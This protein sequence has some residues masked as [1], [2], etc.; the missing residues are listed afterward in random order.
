MR[1]SDDGGAAPSGAPEAQ[2][3]Y[4]DE[5]GWRLHSPPVHSQQS[6]HSDEA[7]AAGFGP[8]EVRSQYSAPEADVKSAPDAQ[9]QQIGQ[10]TPGRPEPAGRRAKRVRHSAPQERQL[11]YL[12]VLCGLVA[13]LL[14]MRLGG[15]NARGGTLAVAGIVLVAALARL[16]LPERRAGMLVTRSRL[17]DV[18]IL[19]AL[20]A[21]VL[22]A[23]LVLPAQP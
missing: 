13:A 18:V 20:G 15:Q 1:L 16:M 6:Q 10:D 7:M 14:W 3:R 5:G 19:S 22:V 2:W 4:S 17:A 23:A 12:I 21:G 9:G 8:P 11:P